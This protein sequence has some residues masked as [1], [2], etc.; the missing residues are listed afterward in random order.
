MLTEGGR[1][2]VSGVGL[3]RKEDIVHVCDGFEEHSLHEE[4]FTLGSSQ[5][6]LLLHAGSAL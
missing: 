4:P 1:T 5:C 2:H 6:V 3:V